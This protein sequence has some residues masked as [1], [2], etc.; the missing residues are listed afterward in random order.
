MFNIK[1]FYDL[2]IHSI[3]SPDADD[4]MTPNNI[5]NMAMLKELDFISITDHNSSLQLPVIEQIASSYDFVVIPGIEVTVLEGFDVLCYFKTF[6]AATTLSTSLS[7]YLTDDFGPW[8]S[9]H[10]V[11]TDIYDMSCDTCCKS[12]THT[13]MPYN[14]LVKE[15][16]K[17]N[18]IIVLAHI[19]RTS[20]SAC[21]KHK[22]TNLIFDGIEIQ[23]Y[24]KEVFLEQNPNYRKYKILTSSD[25]HSLL[26]I[27]EKEQFIDLEEKSIDA[28]FKYFKG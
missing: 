19:K 14:Q 5:L 12:L 23:K 11:I 7:K 2:H 4:L 9:D 28:F 8:T 6:E 21:N 18:G 3:L 22:L 16:Q 13:L 25:A 26:E 27:A 20:K 24:N 15:V 1:Y 10:Q 17:L